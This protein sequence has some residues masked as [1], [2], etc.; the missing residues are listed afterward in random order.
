MDKYDR[1]GKQRSKKASKRAKRQTSKKANNGWRLQWTNVGLDRMS[2][3]S[4]C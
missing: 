1:H 2:T 4:L 3:T